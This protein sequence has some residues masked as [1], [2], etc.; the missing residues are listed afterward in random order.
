MHSNLL[1]IITT[2]SCFCAISANSEPSL[3][4]RSERTENPGQAE[5]RWPSQTGKTYAIKESTDLNDSVG[6]T[7][8][9]SGQQATPPTNI[10][11]VDRADASSR[12]FTLDTTSD[13]IATPTNLLSNTTFNDG[14]THWNTSISGS[15]NGDFSVAGG[16]LVANIIDGGTSPAQVL[17]NQLNIPL[18]QGKEYTL[19]FD[20]R[21][22]AAR[23]IKVNIEYGTDTNTVISQNNNF[24]INEAMTTYSISFTMPDADVTNGKVKFFLGNN[25][26]TVYFDKIELWDAPVTALRNRALRLNERM[27]RGNNFMAAKAIQG[28]GAK[29]DYQLLNTNGFHHCR[30]GYKMDEKT[31]GAPDY[32]IPILD[33]Q[34]LQDMVDWCL[35]EGLIAI[36]DPVHNWA[37]NSNLLTKFSASENN[38]AELEKIWQQIAIHFASYDLEQV[39]FE[40]MNEPHADTDVSRIISTALASIR[41]ITGN[42]ERIVI[43]S[44]DGF[45]TRQALI[46]AFNNDE[47]PANDNHLIGTFHYYDPFTFT[48]QGAGG[49]WLPNISW[50]TEAEFAQVATDFNEV[51]AAN[52]TWANRNN[53]TPIPLYLGEFGVDNEADDWNNDRKRWLSWIRMQAEAHDISWA[54]WNMY[55]NLNNNKG[56]GPWVEEKT[57]PSLRSFDPDPVEALVGHYE[58]EEGTQ[59]GGVRTATTVPGFKGSGY[60]TYPEAT[61][62]NVWARVDSIYIPK[63]DTYAVHIHYASATERTLRL[64]ARNDALVTTHTITEQLFPATG[65]ADT[66]ATQIV[67]VIFEAGDAADLKIVADAVPGVDLDWLRI[68]LP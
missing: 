66:W 29:E 56:M 53:T 25:N 58:F 32:T 49:D 5:L 15:A 38:F 12:F 27:H 45:S 60:K 50:G 39:I 48:K 37:N 46:D 34:R 16:E 14:L 61:G 7:T 43:V 59:G 20:A 11:W 47:I 40:I 63:D 24:A 4:I 52:N 19:R 68:T 51:V 31:G 57:N 42:E 44:G 22:N 3:S 33:M 8:L 26:D 36:I 1:Y 6:F 62:N 10:W 65:G 41:N 35:E 13:S 2:L 55:Q 30:I 23:T 64:V 67:N 21:G 28:N 54:H 17:V 18:V 9:S